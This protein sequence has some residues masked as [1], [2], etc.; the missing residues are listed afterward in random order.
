[1][2]ALSIAASAKLPHG[3]LKSLL[4]ACC[5]A[6]LTLPA[7]AELAPL[8]A[9]PEET[10]WPD[11]GWPEAAG[12]EALQTRIRE[13]LTNEDDPHLKGVRAL[14]VVRGGKLI[15]EGYR[16]GFDRKTHFQSWSMAKSI[17]HALTGILSL[18][19]KL[20]ITAPA[21]VPEWHRRDGDARAGIRLEDLLRMQSGLTFLENY[22]APSKSHALQMLF[23]SGRKDMGHYAASLPLAHAPGTHWSYSS[24]TSN[25]IARILKEAA[26]TQDAAA[27]N[28]FMQEELFKPIGIESAVPEFDA[29]GTLIGSSFVHMTARDWAR[30]GYLYLRDGKW[31]GNRLLP[32]GW[33]DHARRPA[34]HSGGLY[35]AH[36]W[37]NAPDPQTGKPAL[38]DRLP[39][40]VFM[41]RGFG[42]Q[43]VA[44]FPTQDMV[45]VMLGVVYEDDAEPLVNL[46]ADLAESAAP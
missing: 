3:A 37:L 8:P 43:L 46:I 28:T 13:T 38:S 34:R 17:T 22:E 31:N 36:F 33:A 12:P 29:S 4:A 2:S 21:P 39:A 41:A 20:D 19:G 14:L 18:K 27:F 25:I 42:G 10:R 44:I 6:L 16:A 7:Q 15:G 1:M 26:G 24:G 23:G 30:F 40:D 9:Q 35:G 5:L 11:G 32:E 45:L